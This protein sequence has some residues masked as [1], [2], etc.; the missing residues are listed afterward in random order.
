LSQANLEDIDIKGNKTKN[1][2]LW[3]FGIEATTSPINASAMTFFLR[4][5]VFWFYWI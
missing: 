1:I 5:L 3:I 2:V 4:Y